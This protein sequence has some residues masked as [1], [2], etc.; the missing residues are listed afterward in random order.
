MEVNTSLDFD[1]EEVLRGFYGDDD[2]RFNDLALTD[3]GVAPYS[4]GH[5][6]QTM[7]DQENNTPCLYKSPIEQVDI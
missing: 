6:A 7:A 5:H 3:S 2:N 4:A 1:V